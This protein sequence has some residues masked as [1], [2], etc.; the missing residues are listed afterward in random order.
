VAAAERWVSVGRNVSFKGGTWLIE[1]GTLKVVIPKGFIVRRHGQMRLQ[2]IRA[3]ACG[4]ESTTDEFGWC[5]P[6]I[7]GTR[8]PSYF[9]D[10]RSILEIADQVCNI[11][12]FTD[13]E[14]S[15]PSKIRE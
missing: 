5:G 8:R 4:P 11:F 2:T 13:I 12:R 3:A 15:G 9:P 1:L 6:T 7:A 14:A 10:L